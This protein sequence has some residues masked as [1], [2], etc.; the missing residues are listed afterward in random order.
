MR[1]LGTRGIGTV[2]LAGF[3]ALLL[4][5]QAGV[6][7]GQSSEELSSA[8]DASSDQRMEAA[9]E[10]ADASTER[11][12]SPS[13]LTACAS[14]AEATCF[15]N[16]CLAGE[17]CLTQVSCGLVQDGGRICV[18]PSAPG[19]D[20][21]CHRECTGDVDCAAGEACFKYEFFGCFD[22]NGNFDGVC[23]PQDRG[24]E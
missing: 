5:G 11:D 4:T 24:C 23:C 15:E 10:R 2:G 8:P 12:G 7:C 14:R 19:G 1:G 22:Y 18:P 16:G 21:R 17:V 9:S 6:A 3:F 13:S 20:D